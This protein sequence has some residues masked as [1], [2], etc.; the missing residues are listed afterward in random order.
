[1]DVSWTRA[2]RDGTDLDL[3]GYY[4]AYRYWASFPYEDADPRGRYVEIDDALADWIGLEAVLGQ[5]LGRHRMVVGAAG[6][7]NLRILQ[8][9]RYAGQPPFLNDNRHPGLSAV[10]GELELNPH[11]KLSVNLGGRLDHYSAF[12]AASPRLAVM[13]FPTAHT[14]AK[15][16]L[17]GA[18]RAPDPYDEFYV[19]YMDVD[20][21]G[22]HLKPETARAQSILVEHKVSDRISFSGEAFQNDLNKVIEEQLDPVSGLTHFMNEKGDRGRGLTLEA[23][24]GTSSGWSAR[25]SYT[26]EQTEQKLTHV[27]V[28]NSPH[29]LAKLNG[30]APLSAFGRLAMEFLYTAPQQSYLG[31]RV[32]SSFLTNATV[33]TSTRSGW[34]F[35]AGCYNVLDTRWSTPT[36]PEVGAPATVQDGR[37]WRIRLDYRRAVH[38]AP[39][40]P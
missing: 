14:S 22:T 1:M 34:S 26:A 38:G 13:V 21:P 7:Y 16:L 31:S 18:F 2:L 11:P 10:F 40:H 24:V 8:R 33:S 19:D 5:K 23:M 27:P 29:T 35:S 20:A 28:I 9:N 12:A 3:R 30:T 15:Y 17:G 6:E 39:S 4:D 37:T 25:A 32:A 36:G